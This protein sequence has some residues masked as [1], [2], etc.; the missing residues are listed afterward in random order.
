[1]SYVDKHLL[2]GEKV[3]YRT[4]LHWKA[5]IAYW[6]I[7]LFV[8]LP[9]AGWLMFTGQQLFAIIPALAAGIAWMMGSLH[10]DKA[11]F[12]V[13]DRRIIIKLGI[14]STRSIE[15]VLSKVEAIAVSQSMW[16]RMF[17]YGD[18]VVTGSGG[19]KEPFTGIQAPEAFRHAVQLAAHESGGG[20][21]SSSG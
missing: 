14:L 19:T 10:R 20:V 1:M 11:E 13:T 2:P 21:S 5:Y 8:F 7:A 6:L 17:N 16:G 18:I 3:T 15:L 12:A 4:R 9:L